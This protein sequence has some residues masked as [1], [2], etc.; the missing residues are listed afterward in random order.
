[1]SSSNSNKMELE[2]MM[3]DTPDSMAGSESLMPMQLPQQFAGIAESSHT[4]EKLAD[5]DF[6][7]KFDDDCDDESYP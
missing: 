3:M 7:N 2:E 1:M 6:F 5:Q 4:K